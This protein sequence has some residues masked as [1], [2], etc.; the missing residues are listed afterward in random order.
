MKGHRM[1]RLA[2]IAVA[3][4]IAAPPVFA[5]PAGGIDMESDPQAPAQ[6]S[7]PPTDDAPAAA[8]AEPP[9]VVKDPKVAKKWLGAGNT[10]VKQGDKLAKQGKTDEAKTSYT[11]AAV[12]YGKAIESS[13]DVAI[14]L[15]LAN[16]LDKS[17]D[18]IGAMKACKIVLAAEGAKP[19]VMQKAQ[20]KL[21]ELSMKVGVVTLAITPE[22]T[23]I[24]MGGTPVG[25]A[26]LT[27]PLVL[28][29]GT[30]VLTLTAVGYQ[31]KDL[32]VKIEPGSE[33]D[34][35]VDLEPIPM[36]TKPAE[37]E[38]LPEKPVE[39]AGPSRV[40]LYVG[41][42]V[43]AGL[44][45]LATVTGIVAIG[46][47][48]N[49]ESS[50]LPDE[51]AD[52]RSSGKAFALTTDLALLGAAGAAAFTTYWYVVKYRPA[53]RVSAERQ[54]VGPKVDVVPWVQSDAGGFTAV[55]SF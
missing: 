49:Y 52:N 38:L 25:E 30:Y 37:P 16:A 21:D 36:V 15:S 41:G 10:L 50:V 7:P 9:P 53:A 43:T 44:V 8:P 47:H 29:P 34:R 26:P 33:T 2:G 14:Q 6:P 31:P 22:G 46:Y 40:P 51:R 32:E 13:D 4:L 55:G 1:H 18:V 35:K 45:L 12:A 42:G 54:A 3:T 48:G 24:T 5:Q 20:T 28:P 27:E 39:P 17:G 11:N 19:D 23:A